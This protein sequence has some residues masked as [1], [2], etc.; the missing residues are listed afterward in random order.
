RVG[1]GAGEVVAMSLGGVFGRWEFLLVGDPVIE[2]TRGSGRGRPGEVAVGPNA[3][4][5]LLDEAAGSPLADGFVR[6][7]AVRAAA[8]PS[9]LDVPLVPPEADP[10]LLSYIPAAIHRR[11]LARQSGWLAEL[12]RVTVLF[13]SLPDLTHATSLATAQCLMRTLLAAAYSFEL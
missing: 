8:P 10:A 5:L 7:T 4:Q 12:R 11:V 13:V 3:W 6:L 2:A 1:V 9:P